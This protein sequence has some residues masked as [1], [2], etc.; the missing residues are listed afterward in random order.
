MFGAVIAVLSWNSAVR[1]IGAPTAALFGNLIPV[2]TF[3]IAIAGG[4][5]P[6]GYEIG[7][8]LL[9]LGALAAVTMLNRRAAVAATPARVPVRP[10][11][12]ALEAA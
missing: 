1:I 12:Q 2:T 8:T 4:Y 6:D 7:G 9:A 10:P 3:A 11:A 5:S